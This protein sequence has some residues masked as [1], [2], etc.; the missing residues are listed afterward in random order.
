[1]GRYHEGLRIKR[2][3]VAVI[4]DVQRGHHLPGGDVDRNQLPIPAARK[5]NPVLQVER[6][7]CRLLPRSQGMGPHQFVFR[8]VDRRD[9]A[10][11]L[12]IHVDQPL[13]PMLDRRLWLPIDRYRGLDLQCGRVDAG[14]GLRAP[15][16]GP[17]LLGG[18]YIQERIRILS[19]LDLLG[20]LERLQVEDDQL[21]RLPRGREA[22]LQFV[23]SDGSVR[24][25]D[26]VDLS[27]LLHLLQ[28]DDVDLRRMG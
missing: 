6:E 23:D 3:A 11:V 13:L 7:A 18:D 17:D 1:G 16:E 27:D 28:I 26:A 20:D 19:G 12:E 2:D 22:A 9:Q 4:A 24:S 8:D 25:W 5:E 10:L 14:D 15:V 21:V